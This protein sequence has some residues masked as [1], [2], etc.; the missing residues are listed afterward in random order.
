MSG[1]KIPIQDKDIL[2][3]RELEAL[4]QCLECGDITYAIYLELQHE[5]TLLYDN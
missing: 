2:K 4:R 5:L 3:Y 1:H